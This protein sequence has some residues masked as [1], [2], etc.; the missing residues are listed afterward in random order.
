MSVGLHL[1]I[2]HGYSGGLFSGAVMVLDFSS[3]LEFSHSDIAAIG[4]SDED[5]ECPRDAALL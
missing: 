4:F 3:V 2:K 5:S 1:I